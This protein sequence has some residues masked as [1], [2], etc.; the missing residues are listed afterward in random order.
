MKF[1]LLDVFVKLNIIGKLSEN[2]S[3]VSENEARE[4]CIVLCMFKN[5][6]DIFFEKL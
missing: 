1:S 2:D 4:K 5:A 3:A 6:V